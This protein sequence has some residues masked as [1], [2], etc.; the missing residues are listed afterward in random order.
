MERYTPIFSRIVDSSL[1]IEPD[2]VV[3]VFLTMLAKKDSDEIVRGS[4]FNIACWAKKTEAEVLDA[5]KI[6]SSPDTK[7]LEPQPFEGRRIEKVEEGWKLLNGEKYQQEMQ[8]INLRRRKTELQAQ[9]RLEQKMLEEAA[10]G[11]GQQVS[12]SAAS[13]APAV[14][15]QDEFKLRHFLMTL[16]NRREDTAWDVKELKAL[17]VVAKVMPSMEDLQ[18]VADFHN[19]PTTFH[20]KDIVTLLNNWNQEVSRANEWR[21]N[22]NDNQRT[23]GQPGG[24]SERPKT[25]AEQRAGPPLGYDTGALARLRIAAQEAARKPMAT[26]VASAGSN[27]P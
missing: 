3:K 23:A 18:L 20:R 11:A 21:K 25:G 15:P 17:R 6:L 12:A 13:A 14:D 16:F 2:Y 7:R 22:P 19:C 8:K 9:Y 5:L 27:A 26:Q 10:A 24:N 1:W 4:A